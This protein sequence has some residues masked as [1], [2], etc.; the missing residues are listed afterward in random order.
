MRVPRGSSAS[1]RRTAA[2]SS[3]RMYE[4]SFRRYSF[5]VRTT[6]AFET[7]PFLTLPPGHGALDGDDDLVADA[8]VPAAAAAEY[9]DAEHLLGAGVI[10]HVEPGFLLDHRE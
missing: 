9:A 1:L 6:T 2:F 10:G 8:G 3:N 7:W 5:L 4:P